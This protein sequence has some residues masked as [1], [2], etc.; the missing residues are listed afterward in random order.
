VE[1]CIAIGT[2]DI[3]DN[4]DVTFVF[5]ANTLEK[6]YVKCA[7]MSRVFYTCY[8][9]MKGRLS[10]ID[11]YCHLPFLTVFVESYPSRL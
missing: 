9:L 3:C 7:G 5:H 1:V 8:Q 4:I 10:A 6:K 11:H 2:I